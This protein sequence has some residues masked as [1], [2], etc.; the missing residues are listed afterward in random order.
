MSAIAQIADNADFAELIAATPS[1]AF[2]LASHR[3]DS[4]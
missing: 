1:E 3:S 2:N 4:R